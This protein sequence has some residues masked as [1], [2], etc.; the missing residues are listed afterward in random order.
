MVRP[1]LSAPTIIL[2]FDADNID[3]S[4]PDY[5]SNRGHRTRLN[6]IPGLFGSFVPTIFVS[7]ASIC[8]YLSFATVG[9]STLCDIP[10]FRGRTE[11]WTLQVV[12]GGI[13]YVGIAGLF[14]LYSISV[15]GVL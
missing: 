9:I 5:D 3:F 14:A 6:D 8:I 15:V 2:T 13:C 10:D 12:H 11:I 1:Q 4:E 7:F